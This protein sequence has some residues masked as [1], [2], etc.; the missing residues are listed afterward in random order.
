ML[1]CISSHGNSKAPLL[2]AGT[3]TD[4]LYIG[5]NLVHIGPEL[6]SHRTMTW[7]TSEY[8]ALARCGSR[9]VSEEERAELRIGN[10]LHLAVYVRAW[11]CGCVGA[12]IQKCMQKCMRTK[13]R[14]RLQNRMCACVR[15]C[16]HACAQR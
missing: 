8:G 7:S 4:G 10:M 16:V 6:G 3:S 1:R 5:Q 11:V 14:A 9:A 12:C 15:A 13:V 2:W